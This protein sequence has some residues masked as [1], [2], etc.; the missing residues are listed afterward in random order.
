MHRKKAHSTRRQ[1]VDSRVGYQHAPVNSNARLGSLGN[2]KDQLV[3]AKPTTVTGVRC[4]ASEKQHIIVP[5][6]SYIGMPVP[7]RLFR[8]PGRWEENVATSK[9]IG[10]GVSM[11][12]TN[13]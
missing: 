4:A 3:T 13:A 12:T 2:V 10:S 6:A 8:W 7:E 1:R 9:L 5:N 11:V